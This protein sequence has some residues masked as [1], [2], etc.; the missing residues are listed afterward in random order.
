MNSP[1]VFIIFNRPDTT[2]QVFD[3]IRRAKPSK[4]LVIADG[5]RKNRV[6]EAE[7]C[8]ATRTIV[9]QVDWDCEIFRNYSTDNLGCANRVSSG[10]NWAFDIVEEAIILEDDCVPD[11]TFF[12]YCDELLTHYRHDERIMS[13]CGLSVPASQ[14]RDNYSYHFSRYQRCWGWASWRRAWQHYDLEMKLWPTA[15]DSGLLKDILL[16]EKALKF[17]TKKFQ[18][19]FDKSI[20]TWDYQWTFA[21]WMQNGLNI[22]PDVNLIHNI[23]FGADATHTTS[24]SPPTQL[25]IQSMQ[26]P[27]SHPP[28][29]VRDHKADAFIQRTRHSPTLI[30]RLAIKAKGGL[31]A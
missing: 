22:L 20:D 31:S 1:I 15:R 29:I 7:K 4:L 27:L 18:S 3:V 28:F 11:P 17:W 12:Q 26:F 9:E 24:A 25:T 2:Q 16:D 5:P 19:V 6:G 10:L 21:C 14:R 30:D 8:A 13:V 23:G